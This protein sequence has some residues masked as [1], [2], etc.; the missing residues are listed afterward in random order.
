VV[1]PVGEDIRL[2]L[3]VIAEDALDCEAACV[4]LRIDAFNDYLTATE[5]AFR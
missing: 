5:G 2:H 4:D 1:V 3:H